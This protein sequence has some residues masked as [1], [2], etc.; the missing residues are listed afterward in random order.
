MGRKI[1]VGSTFS[2]IGAFEYALKKLR[3]PHEI[4]FAGDIDRFVK[5]S[6]FANYAM[7]ETRW[8]D[9]IMRFCALEFKNKIDI[10]VGVALVKAFQ[11]WA[12]EGGLE[13]LGGLCFTSLHG[14]LASA[15][16]KRLF[17]KMSRG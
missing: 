13:T 16:L 7:D 11:W 8:H 15:N 4:A 17:M 9:D 14:S 6:Y 1:I 12:K 10:L 5:Q 3:V 2:G